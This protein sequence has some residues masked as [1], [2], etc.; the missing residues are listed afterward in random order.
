MIQTARLAL[1]PFR[2]DDLS[3]VKAILGDPNVMAFS[4]DGA[5]EHTA[6]C[7]WL[8]R[9]KQ[10]TTDHGMPM[11]LAICL[12]SDG[13]LIGYVSLAKDP[14][15]VSA[16]EA[17]LGFRLAHDCWGRGIATEAAQAM[18][19]HATCLPGTKRIVAIVDP[20]NRQSVRVLQKIGMTYERDVMFEG[21]DYPDHRF[22]LELAA[23]AH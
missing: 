9:A 16:C 2:E 13:R 14:H 20:N 15:R 23:A 3:R 4:D 19:A 11:I 21:Y 8:N 12:K 22:S 18:V 5:L 17:E 1:R 10:T 7:E 6:C